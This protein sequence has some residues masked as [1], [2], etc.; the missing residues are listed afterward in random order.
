[1]GSEARALKGCPSSYAIELRLFYLSLGDFFFACFALVLFCFATSWF[2]ECFGFSDV[3][4]HGWSIF[5]KF[6]F[7]TMCG[8]C[9]FAQG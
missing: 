7:H 8:F 5:F 6:I 3:F 4:D 2:R 9:Y 1:M